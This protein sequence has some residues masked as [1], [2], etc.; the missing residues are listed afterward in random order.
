MSSELENSQEIARHLIP[1][2]GDVPR[3]EGVDIFA[4]TLALSCSLGGDLVIYLDFTQF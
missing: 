4:G 2:P 3:V 1:T